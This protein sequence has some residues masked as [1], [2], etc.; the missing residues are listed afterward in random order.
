MELTAKEKRKKYLQRTLGVVAVLIALNIAASYIHGR[1]DLTAEKR[2][3]LAAS[4]RNMLRQLDA[5]VY[6][7]VYLKG[8]YPASFRQLGDATRELLE[9]FQEYGGK[10]IRFSFVSPG[11]N[12]PDSLRMSFQDSLMAKGILPFNLQ[13][14]ENGQDSYAEKLIFPGATIRYKD[15]ENSVNLLK[16]QGGMDPMQALNSSVALLEYRFANAIYQLQQTERPLVGYMLGHGEP[17]G[18]NI[19]DALKTLHELYQVDTINLK[20]DSHIPQEFDA[21]LFV[22]PL[23]TFTDEDKLKIDQYVMNGGKVL[24]FIDN[25]TASADS[26][27]GR[28]FVAFDRNLQLE[29][30][31]FKYGARVNLDLV[32]DLQSDMIPLVVGN[33]GDKPQIRPIPFPFFPL[34]TPGN[35]HPIV[36]NMDLIMSRFASSIDTIKG[37]GIRKTVLLATSDHSRT[38]GGPV[39]ISLESVQ[40]QPNQRDFRQRAIPVAVLLEG[41]FPSLFNHRL[42]R[43]QHQALQS[44]SGRPFKAMADTLNRM[45]VVGDADIVTNALS[46]KEGPLQMGVNEFNPQYVF[47]NK[48]FFL[49]SMEYLTSKTPI[50]DTRS[51]ELTL[52][53]LDGEKLK[54]DKTLWQVLAFALPIGAILLFAMV[55]QFIRQ[56]KYAG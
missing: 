31:L 8:Q 15:R 29:D 24:W 10:N 41:R 25:L 37:G 56:R 20:T 3:T 12:L 19:Y 18:P 50:M 14:Q 34:L 46:Q 27:R 43:E 4:T 6:I 28:E 52:R 23:E 54:K 39:R 22:R 53:L 17:E 21:V 16:S 9:E 32:Q 48:E 42:S 13:V 51:K 40:Q 38:L 2:Y 1:W 55:F 5:P 11:T 33:I 36:K 44:A 49:N 30:L 7:E 35:T 26:L 47:A 45:I